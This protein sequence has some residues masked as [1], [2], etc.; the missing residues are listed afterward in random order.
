MR[1]TCSFA[2]SI[3]ALSAEPPAVSG[4]QERCEAVINRYI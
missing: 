2:A 4:K 3:G 1:F